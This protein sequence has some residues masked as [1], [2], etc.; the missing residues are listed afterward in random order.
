MYTYLE[1]FLGNRMRHKVNLMIFGLFVLLS[2][3]S[4]NAGR[5]LSSEKKPVV[6]RKCCP[7]GVSYL[8]GPGK[9][10]LEKIC[11]TDNHSV[12][13]MISYNLQA[14]CTNPQGTI[15]TD[16]NGKKYP[17]RSFKGIPHCK[18]DGFRKAAPKRFYWYFDRLDPQAKKISLV[19]VEDEITAG[20]YFWAWRNI[21]LSTCR[22]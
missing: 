13:Y 8:S 16:Q 15:L 19:E 21:D 4:I 11:N 3:Q 10:M 22:F 6:T 12:F 17:M 9:V 1:S 20:L 5:D 18:N 14:I 7:V 2:H